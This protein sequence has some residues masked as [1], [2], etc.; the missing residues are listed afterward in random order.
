MSKK[1]KDS[2]KIIVSFVGGS[3]TNITGSSVLISYPTSNTERKLICLE[4]G[5][6]QGESKPEYEYSVN[7]KMIENIPVEDVSAVF[8]MHSHVPSRSHRFVTYIL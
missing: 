1:K 4:A 6:I 7:K 5:M 2:D 3:R 8:V